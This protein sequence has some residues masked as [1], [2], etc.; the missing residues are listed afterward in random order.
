MVKPT[1]MQSFMKSIKDLRRSSP[2]KWSSGAYKHV[3][4]HPKKYIAG[5]AAVAGIGV[6]SQHQKLNKDGTHARLKKA[7]KNKGYV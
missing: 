1:L 5:A 6:Y 3:T 4:K 2:D 7:L